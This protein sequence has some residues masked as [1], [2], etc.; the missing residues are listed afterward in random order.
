MKKSNLLF[1]IGALIVGIMMILREL[2]IKM[3]DFVEGLGLGM[4]IACELMGAYAM[5]HDLSKL[6]N[7]KKR[8]LKK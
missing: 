8:L 2:S 7:F 3:P 4:G 6:R 5:N 1:I